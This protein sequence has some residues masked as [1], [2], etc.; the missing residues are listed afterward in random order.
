[1]GDALKAKSGKFRVIE[2]RDEGNWR[3][4]KSEGDHL[5][6]QRARDCIRDLMNRDSE[7]GIDDGHPSYEI[8]DDQGQ[9]VS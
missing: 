3:G 4:V 5:D 8:R 9:L 6:L 7:F 2:R 1:M